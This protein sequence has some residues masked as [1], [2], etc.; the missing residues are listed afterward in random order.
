MELFTAI[1]QV[2]NLQMQDIFEEIDGDSHIQQTIHDLLL[3]SCV[4]PG[5]SVK[6]GRLFYKDRLVLPKSSR[7]IDVILQEYHS[8]VFGGHS[9]LLKTI[10]RIQR[11]FHWPNL[12]KDVQRF[13]S[14]CRVCQTHKSS[15][16]VPA[17]NC[18]TNANL[19][20]VVNGFHWGIAK[21]KR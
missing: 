2:M 4:K 7:F 1:T 3:G 12:K 10:K 5:F 6:K 20:G 18:V 8:G 13:V 16:L 14:E 19:E 17:T 15:T 21:I 11:L 9:G